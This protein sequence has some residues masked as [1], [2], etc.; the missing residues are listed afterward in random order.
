MASVVIGVGVKAFPRL[1]DMLDVAGDFAVCACPLDC[2]VLSYEI[3]DFLVAAYPVIVKGL[4]LG[5]YLYAVSPG[6]SPFS[7]TTHRALGL[8]NTGTNRPLALVHSTAGSHSI[9]CVT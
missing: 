1:S 4:T 8:Y 6:Y 9:F 7:L 3:R 5:R 2:G